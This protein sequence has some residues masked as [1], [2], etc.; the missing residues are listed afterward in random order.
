MEGTNIE[1]IYVL[2]NKNKKTSQLQ[3]L[4]YVK[5]Y[6]KVRS[7]HEISIKALYYLN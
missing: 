4:N 3:Y 7:L 2:P 1:Q 6:S 5:Y